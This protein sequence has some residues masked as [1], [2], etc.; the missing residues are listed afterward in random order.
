[1]DELKAIAILKEVREE[2]IREE[3]PISSLLTIGEAIKELEE[4]S[5]Q[6]RLAELEKVIL[7]YYLNKGYPINSG[8][9]GFEIIIGTKYK[10]KNISIILYNFVDGKRE[11]EDIAKNW[12]SSATTKE[13]F[14]KAI[15]YFKP[16]NTNDK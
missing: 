4:L 15:E 13:M 9:W 3:L 6:D 8:D 10:Q 11:I 5:Y 1:M 12:E 16:V 14:D 7:D 2:I